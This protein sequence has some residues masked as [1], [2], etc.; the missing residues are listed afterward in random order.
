LSAAAAELK[1][2]TVHRDKGFD[3][4]VQ[5]ISRDAPSE[6]QCFITRLLIPSRKRYESTLFAIDHHSTLVLGQKGLGLAGETQP[7]TIGVESACS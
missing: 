3:R 4:G 2:A 6:I 7:T 5:G 1:S